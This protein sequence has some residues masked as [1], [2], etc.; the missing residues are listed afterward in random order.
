MKRIAPID[1]P[2]D[3]EPID[4]LIGRK[5]RQFS[6][7]QKRR[8]AENWL[9]IQIPEHQGLPF[10]VAWVGDM[11]IDNPGCDIARLSRDLSTIAETPGLYGAFLGDGTDNW[12]G[13]LMRLYAEHDT[14]KRD[15]LRLLRWA[16]CETGVPWLFGLLGNHDKW[17][18]G[19]ILL[20]LL[21]QHSQQPILMMN[22]EA[23][24][25]IRAGR[26]SWKVHAA[27]NFKGY[28]QWNGTHGLLK[29]A[30]M[31]SPAELLV[32]GHLHFAGLQS[33]EIPEQQRVVH[34]ARAAGYKKDDD[35]ALQ[36]GFPEH[37]HGASVM[38][39]FDPQAK[40]PAQRIQL[41]YDLDQGAEMLAALRAYREK[42]NSKPA[43]VS[44][45]KPP[46][47]PRRK[48]AKNAVAKAR[49]ANTTKGAKV[50]GK[51]AA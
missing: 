24:V 41:F 28:S 21:T 3:A 50:R 5:A 17:N 26:Q 18:D 22:W 29:R 1:L 6:R 8:D 49:V 27:H 42:I 32:A 33:F 47:K 48:P 44:K 35:H 23:K 15:G 30:V 38:A 20:D 7:R 45:P 13:R 34:V 4:E 40:T 46:T 36:G 37:E 19:A 11:H 14:S 31:G 10:G 12:V 43:A 16:L 25:E 2:D 51:R 9:P 39:I